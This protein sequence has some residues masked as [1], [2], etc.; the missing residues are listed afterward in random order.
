MTGRN[1]DRITNQEKRH[2]LATFERPSPAL[3]VATIA[4]IVARNDSIRGGV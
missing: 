2:E 3:L 1:D 4:L